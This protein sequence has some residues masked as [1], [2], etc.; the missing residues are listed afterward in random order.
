MVT[1][2]RSVH[3]NKIQKMFASDARE[4]IK[5]DEKYHKWLNDFNYVSKDELSI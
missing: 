5:A 2:I 3:K 4:Y 1:H